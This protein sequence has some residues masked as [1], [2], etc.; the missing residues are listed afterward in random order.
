MSWTLFR[1]VWQLQ[2]PLYV[3]AEPAGAINRTRLYIPART[4]WG[5]ITAQIAR[6][7]AGNAFPNY[8]AIGE[9]IQNYARFSYLFPGENIGN[10]WYAWLPC[11][12]QGK[13][14]VWQREDGNSPLLN[15][16]QFRMRLLSTRAAT[17]IEPSSDSA[18][19]GSL[20]E[21]ECINTKWRDMSGRP[22]G[23]VAMVG[24]VFVHAN[25][26]QGIRQAL[27]ALE[28][29]TIGGDTR[30]GLGQL[31]RVS[32]AQAK[33]LFGCAVNGDETNPCVMTNRILGHAD[34]SQIQSQCLQGQ[35]EILLGWNRGKLITETCSSPLW[36]PGST[37]HENCYW[38]ILPSGIWSPSQ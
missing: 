11:Y 38:H 27:E 36:C 1:W 33:D 3:G 2:S 28:S 22:A 23:S 30:Y 9:I 25:L 32:C 19:E 16:R 31:K 13:G 20:R 24:Y 15:N 8:D 14:L 17:A 4:L 35:M 5:A 21:T 34:G 6:S 10:S 29:I 18:E 12:E 7:R 26:D 37:C